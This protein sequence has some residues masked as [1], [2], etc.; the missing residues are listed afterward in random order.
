MPEQKVCSI[1]LKPYCS[2]CCVFCRPL[3]EDSRLPS[4]ALDQLDKD[5]F[6]A[7]E[8]F[9]KEGFRSIEVSGGDP[10]EYRK[11]FEVLGSLRDHGFRWIRISTNGVKLSD[12]GFADRLLKYGVNVFRIPLYG[13]C[14]EIHD[15]VTRAKG[16][17]DSTVEGIRY[18][19]KK[20]KKTKILLTCLLLKQNALSLNDTFDLMVRLGCD[21]L[22][23]ATPYISNKEPQLYYIPHKLQNPFF[24][25]LIKHAQSLRRP[26]K[27]KDVPYCVLGSDNDFSDN[28]GRPAYLGARFQPPPHVRTGETNLPSYREKI[29]LPM[30]SECAVSGKCHG[31]IKNDVLRY[32][33]G[34]LKPVA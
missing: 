33:T 18:L 26:I 12:H 5:T 30:C 3:Q 17:F 27:L 14:A 15:S 24:A 9:A 7:I 11:I 25:R 28:T 20:A 8:E 2:N 34:D 21:D 4:A 29:K 19:K 32:G 13:P 6:L 31:L 16:S 1:V 23:F 22:Y 10:L